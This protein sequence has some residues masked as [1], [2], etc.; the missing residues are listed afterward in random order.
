VATGFNVVDR[1]AFNHV[2]ASWTPSQVNLFVNGELVS[3]VNITS[4]PFTLRFID[5]GTS[6]ELARVLRGRVDE[7]RMSN[8][9]RDAA[10]ARFESR[11]VLDQLVQL[12]VVEARP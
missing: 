8:T 10:F 3:T 4:V 7:L 6:Q 9:P 1:N 12:G 11:S 2:T 5:I